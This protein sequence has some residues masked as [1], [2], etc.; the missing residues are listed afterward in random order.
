MNDSSLYDLALKLGITEKEWRHALTVINREPM[1]CELQMIAVMWSEHCSYKSSKHQLKRL[2]TKAPQVLQGPGE[3]AGLVALDEKRA[4]SFKIESHNHPSF[5]E[6]FQGAATG[7]GGILRD[8]FTM[9]AK[10]IAL[11]NY[12]RFGQLSIPRHQELVEGVVAGIAHYGNCMGIP[13]TGGHVSTHSRYNGNIL[14][15]V[16]ALGLVDRD[17]IFKSNTAAPDGVVMVW[18]A[19]TGRDGIHGASLLASTHF[20]S[21]NSETLEQK[22]RVQVGDPFLEKVLMEATLESMKL[23]GDDI[24]AIQD[25]GAAGLT[26]STTEIASKSGVG[27]DLDLEHVP[28]REEGMQP[29]ELLLSESQERMLAVVRKGSEKKFQAILEKWG[30][31]SAVIGKT[32][33]GGQL[34]MRFKGETVVDLPIDK[35]M[36]PPPADLPAAEWPVSTNP[37]ID[38]SALPDIRGEADVLVR[39]LMEPS[40]AYKEAIYGRFDTTVGNATVFGP[41]HEA[42]V[43]WTPS[44]EHP[45]LGIAFK[46]AAEEMLYA[47]DPR[48]G[49]MASFLKTIR[50]LA[51]VGS[52]PLAYTDGLNLGDPYTA[53][54][55]AALQLTVDGFNAVAEAFGVPCISGNVSLHNKTVTQGVAVNIPPTNFV[56]TVGRVEDVRKALPSV[57]QSIGSEVWL[58]EIPESEQDLPWSSLYAHLAWGGDRAFSKLPRV[59]LAGEKRLFELLKQFHSRNLLKSSRSVGRGGLAV[60]LVKSCFAEQ[61][62]GFD[63]DLSKTRKRRDELLF[64]E[65]PGKIIVEIDPKNRAELMQLSESATILAKKIGVVSSE[66][67]FCLRPT[68]ATDIHKLGAAWKSTFV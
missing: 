28:Q 46:G 53:E 66:P 7:V 19:K 39:L 22:I 57:F 24:L 17:F 44:K 56:V 18:G 55:Q 49:A 62:F 35:L 6:P 45:H 26:S 54:T 48:M 31:D 32:T 47:R 27:M 2:L 64:G 8:V 34:V 25:M 15:N 68:L 58:L 61:V 40:V 5:V 14:V 37:E 9:G 33:Q 30:C 12:L 50:S 67:A 29:W 16:F 1:I 36:D 10:P 59:D 41:G 51:C 60:T 13:V 63:G 21:G 52:E 11:G 43:H 20:E 3:N 23:H 65:A 38:K 4:I 42:A